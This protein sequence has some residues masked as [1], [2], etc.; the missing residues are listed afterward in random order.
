MR[1]GESPAGSG[2]VQ[3]L[4]PYALPVRFAAS[5]AT[6]DGQV[7]DIELHRERVVLRR[8]V[9][10]MRMA[11]NMPVSAYDGV[12][13]KVML[14]G[15]AWTEEAA[16]AV[17]L[18]HK[19]PSL[20]LPLCVTREV[21]EAFVEWRSWSQALG[22]PL[23][24]QDGSGLREPFA[25]MGHVSIARPRPRRRRRSVL[26]GRRPLILLRRIFSKLSE[27]ALVH[28]GEHEIIARN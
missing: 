10:G 2:R 4:D 7:R 20:M 3:R 19:D 27:T 1:V 15:E 11:I 22:L 23:L 18:M 28:R 13:L 8:C 9:R 25:R 5:D 16:V 26:K 14:C 6:A 21:D 17:V 12:A 24:V